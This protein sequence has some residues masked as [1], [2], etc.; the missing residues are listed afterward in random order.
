MVKGQLDLHKQRLFVWDKPHKSTYFSFFFLAIGVNLY[1]GS[2]LWK[3]SASRAVFG[4]QIVG[5]AITAAQKSVDDLV[6]LV[7][8]LHCYFVNPTKTNPMSSMR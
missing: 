3:R 1:R 5:Q 2:N 8:S 6:F 4:G 7:H